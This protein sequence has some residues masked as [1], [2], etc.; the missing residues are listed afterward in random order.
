MLEL[1]IWGAHHEQTGAP[2]ELVVM[3]KTNREQT[4]LEVRRRWQEHDLTPMI[5]RFAKVTDGGSAKRN[6]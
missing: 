4:L 2:P 3:L 1:L 5:P 6:R